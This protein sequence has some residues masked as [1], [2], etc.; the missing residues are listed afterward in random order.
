MEITPHPRVERDGEWAAQIPLLDVRLRP[1]VGA[2]DAYSVRETSG[3]DRFLTITPSDLYFPAE[4]FARYRLTTLDVV[5]H[6]D[7]ARVARAL[8]IFGN[9]A[10]AHSRRCC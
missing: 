7:R 3:R 8:L 5:R 2:L 6:T 1:L 4:I 9:W 10:I